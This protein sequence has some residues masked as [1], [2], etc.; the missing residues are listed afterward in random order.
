[1]KDPRRHTLLLPFLACALLVAADGGQGVSDSTRPDPSNARNAEYAQDQELALGSGGRRL[2]LLD[3]ARADGW[4][5]SS[6][7]LN[8]RL[9]LVPWGVGNQPI[10]SP[11]DRW[12]EVLSR[13]PVVQVDIPFPLVSD[14]QFVWGPDVGAFDLRS[15]LKAHN[16]PLEPYA[17]EIELWSS[18]SSVSPKV[19]LAVLEVRDGL[20]H[21]LPRGTS[22]EEIRARIEDTATDLAMAYYEH[23]YLWGSRRPHGEASPPAGPALVFKDKSVALLDRDLPSGTVAVAA[24][25]SE[26]NDIFDFQRQVSPYGGAGSFRGV[27]GALF[28][29]VNPLDTSTAVNPAG[30]PPGDLLQFPFPLGATWTASGPHSWYGGSYPPPY[31]SIDFFTGGATCAKPPNLYTVAAATGDSFRPSGYRCWVEVD[32]GNGWVT[33]Y[34]HLKN[35]YSGSRIGRN[36]KLGTIA[37][38]ICAGG[39]ATGPH[40]HFSLKYNGAYVSLEGVNL[41][42]WTVHVGNQPY[43][44]GSFVRRQVSL[45]AY[46]EILNDYH[47]Y[48]GIANTSLRFYGTSSN[49]IDRVKIRMTDLTIGPPADVGGEDFTIEWWMKALPGENASPPVECGPNES[50]RLGNILLDRDRFGQDRDYGVSIAGDRLVFGVTGNGTD[51]LSLC[52]SSPITDGVWHHVAIQRRRSDGWMWI[53]VDGA[54]DASSD[55]PDGDVSYPNDAVPLEACNGPC[56]ND[57]FLVIGAEK[58]GLDQGALS[59]SGW[60]DE[61]RFSNVLRYQQSFLRP[62]TPFHADANTLAL[63]PLDDS[64]GRTAF[65]VSGYPG[66]PSN[67][68]IYR[69]GS[70]AVPEWSD[71]TPFNQTAPPPTTETPTAT[72]TPTETATETA[73]ATATPTAPSS[74]T[75]T[76]TP[77][78]EGTQTATPTA[79]TSS[80][81]FIDVPPDYWA[82]EEIE[83][84]FKAN[85]IAGCSAEPRMYCPEGAMSRA[86]S[87]VFVERGVHGAGWVP[88]PPTE[89]VFADIPIGED[90]A[91]YAKWATALW[92]DGFTA[93]CNEEPRM[94]CADFK[95]SRA[96]GAVFFL[97]MLH[98]AD[99]W[100]PEAGEAVFADVPVGEQAQ[101]YS[102]WIY[103][104]YD[105]DL[106]LPC[107]ES[108]DLLYCPEDPLTRA[109]AAYMMVQAKGGL[110]LP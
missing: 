49:D 98:G 110:P 27:L 11:F 66:G 40:V 5:G 69:G 16:S 105:D 57:P 107:A 72:P 33:S 10:W 7:S 88:D 37:C 8:R 50:W 39:F 96:E 9:D 95:H 93:G 51:A 78:P 60:L 103:A 14:G 106:L 28:P 58:H 45:P 73:T 97:R 46:S 41:S 36:G 29:E 23:L 102:D 56:S 55:G 85:Y 68:S 100:P 15:F 104:A 4:L 13:A 38:E 84:L 80:Q 35:S 63:L 43:T 21:F 1:M 75:P 71:D 76:E 31:S 79:T 62:E 30:P 24:A 87:A 47:T 48:F 18:Y 83:A 34:Y 86:E 99:Y 108:P 64:P 82:Y 81:T 12:L 109:T 25:L 2:A 26:G 94:F 101:W 19:L 90:Q 54:L 61:L 74:P 42:G 44:S 77:A 22:P 20:F 70:P 91:W 6:P 89:Q 92:Y 53:F 67:G 52:G 59:F 17:P 65:D 3:G 32:H